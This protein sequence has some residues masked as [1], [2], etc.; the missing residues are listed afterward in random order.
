[1]RPEGHNARNTTR[2]R[3]S[4]PPPPL[5]ALSPFSQGASIHKTRV[6]VRLKL[7]SEGGGNARLK[8]TG[9]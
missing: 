9:G 4:L 1:M 3:A 5:P 6:I 2:T 8:F 7:S